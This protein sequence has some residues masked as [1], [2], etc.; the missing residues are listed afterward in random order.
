MEHTKKLLLIDPSRAAQLY[1]PTTSDKKLSKLDEDISSTLNSD[2]PDDEK[3]KRYM[4]TL[5]SLRFF[6]Q[7][8]AAP[9]A[10]PDVDILDSVEPQV[11]RKAKRLLKRVKPHLRLSD[12][13]EIVHG[14]Q[15]VPDSDI[16]DL[17]NSTLTNTG[18]KPKG[19]TAFA[20]TLKRARVPRELISNDKLWT[21]IN[22]KSQRSIRSRGWE[23]F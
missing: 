2:L 6:D 5:K 14:A 16:I 12:D 19:W 22:P 18:S 15:L 20:D 8:L 3:A 17:L 10:D 23:E 7:P 11:R 1:R 21:Y 9:A 4:L 13:G